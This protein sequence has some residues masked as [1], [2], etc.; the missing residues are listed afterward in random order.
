MSKALRVALLALLVTALAATASLA[1]GTG[2]KEGD[3]DSPQVML[4][5]V[6]PSAESRGIDARGSSGQLVSQRRHV[7]DAWLVLFRTYLRLHG[8][9][10]GQ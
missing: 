4:P 10:F 3:P 2:P 6:G 5:S 8:V 7:S 1:G 9:H